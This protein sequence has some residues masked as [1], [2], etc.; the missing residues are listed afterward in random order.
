M[1]VITDVG[2][3]INFYLEFSQDLLTDLI[4][5]KRDLLQFTLVKPEV[6]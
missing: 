2:T 6:F 4:G 1:N 5:M 3:A